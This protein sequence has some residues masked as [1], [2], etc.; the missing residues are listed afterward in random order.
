MIHVLT[1]EAA[2][3]ETK[4][5]EALPACGFCWDSMNTDTP[6]YCVCQQIPDQVFGRLCCLHMDLMF[7]YEVLS[8]LV[9][10]LPTPQTTW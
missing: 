8:L 3:V 10:L 6:F 1:R 7:F 9:L 2:G 5:P 4:C